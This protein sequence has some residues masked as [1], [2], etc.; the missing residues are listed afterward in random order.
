MLLP[1][2]RPFHWRL[3]YIYL[4][5]LFSPYKTQVQ[6]QLRRAEAGNKGSKLQRVEINISI[7]SLKVIDAKSHVRSPFTSKF[8]LVSS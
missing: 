2:I 7:D 8:L 3:V 1:A 6:W 5:F 4:N